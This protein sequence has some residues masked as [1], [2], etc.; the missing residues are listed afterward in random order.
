[1]VLQDAGW[2]I[3]H[4]PPTPIPVTTILQSVDD[5]ITQLINYAPTQSPPK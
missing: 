4:Q 5:T 1:V 3:F 2:Q